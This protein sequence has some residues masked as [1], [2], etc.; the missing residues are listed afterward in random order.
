MPRP[1]P[2]VDLVLASLSER[3]AREYK[4]ALRQFL[5]YCNERSIAVY[6]VSQLDQFLVRYI[7]HEFESPG[8]DGRGHLNKVVSAVKIIFP[9]AAKSLFLTHRAL[10]GWAKLRPSQ[11]MTPCP[12]DLALGI[13]YY[14]RRADKPEMSLAVL[15]FF[16]IA[17][18][19]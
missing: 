14:L 13:F 1:G 19:V 6:N 10:S 8:R 11:H 4:A 7:H 9:E 2:K 17:T 15:L 16:L 3:T 18:Y 12:F 5:Q